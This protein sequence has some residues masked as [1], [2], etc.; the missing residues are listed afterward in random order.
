MSNKK[1]SYLHRRWKTGPLEE[2][3]GIHH[4]RVSLGYNTQIVTADHSTTQQ[5]TWFQ[6]PGHSS[7]KEESKKSQLHDVLKSLVSYSGSEVTH[8]VKRTENMD[9]E[10]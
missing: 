8:T 4:L 2:T 6:S 3:A 7:P 5:R 9:L 1:L 10:P